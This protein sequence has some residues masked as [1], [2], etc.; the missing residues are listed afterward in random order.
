MWLLSW[1]NTSEIKREKLLFGSLEETF[2]IQYLHRD[3]IMTV[4]YIQI[5]T[6]PEKVEGKER[7]V[8]LIPLSRA[9][10]D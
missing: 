8:P 2:Q 6:K 3:S 9:K 5:Y 7:N 10:Q 4:E 1:D